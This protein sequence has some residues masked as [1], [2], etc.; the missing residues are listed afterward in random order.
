MHLIVEPSGRPLGVVRFL[1]GPSACA[2]P[3]PVSCGSRPKTALSIPG[4]QVAFAPL[5]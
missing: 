5:G 1:P 3:M 4:L 2:D